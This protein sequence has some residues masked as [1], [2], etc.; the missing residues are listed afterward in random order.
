MFEKKVEEEKIH[1]LNKKNL[2]FNEPPYQLATGFINLPT[3]T[4][5]H[6]L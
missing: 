6:V 2:A 1:D 3:A 4:M 5:I